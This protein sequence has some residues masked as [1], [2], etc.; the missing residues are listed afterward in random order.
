MHVSLLIIVMISDIRVYNI[1]NDR[2]GIR[3]WGW[4]TSFLL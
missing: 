2:R 4:C 3:T 1:I